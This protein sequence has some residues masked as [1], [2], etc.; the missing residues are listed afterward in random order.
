MR[1][2]L[3]S[4][5]YCRDLLVV[6]VQFQWSAPNP[7][8]LVPN[9]IQFWNKIL[10]KNRIS[11]HHMTPNFIGSRLHSVSMRKQ[12][13]QLKRE[14]FLT[15]RVSPWTSLTR[16][17]GSGQG[18]IQE[19][20]LL[21]IHGMANRQVTDTPVYLLW[22]CLLWVGITMCYKSLR[23]PA[24][25]LR[26]S[27]SCSCDHALEGLE[28]GTYHT[29]MS[30]NSIVLSFCFLPTLLWVVL[31]LRKKCLQYKHWK[32]NFFRRVYILVA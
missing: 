29:A 13:S 5:T 9:N 28:T 25:Q 24:W 31:F 30:D 8:F 17:G 14:S 3:S 16:G 26:W 4:D 18:P 19:P 6:C 22:W 11:S 15:V 12:M 1:Q 10:R 2:G 27:L 20:D 32:W 23:Q 21:W 7:R